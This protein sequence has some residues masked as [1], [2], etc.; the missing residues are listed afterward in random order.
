M[1]GVGTRR[2][3]R[4]GS[5]TCCR[6]AA[7]PHDHRAQCT[8]GRQLHTDK[9]VCCTHPCS[10]NGR[11]R[12]RLQMPVW[13]QLSQ[14]LMMMLLLPQVWPVL[15]HVLSPVSPLLMLWL[16]LLPQVWPPLL[17][18]PPLMMTSLQHQD[19]TDCH[20]AWPCKHS[21]VCTHDQQGCTGS[22]PG[23][24]C[25]RTCSTAHQAQDLHRMALC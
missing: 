25:P 5:C 24:M 19:G 20:T 7:Q 1:T 18:L 11:T 14:Q 17:L 10:G 15:M 23:D 8:A 16:L 22:G 21:G 12:L 13:P 4:T 9:S 2:R 3:S 6:P